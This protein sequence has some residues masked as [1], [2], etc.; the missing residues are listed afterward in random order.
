MFQLA[1]FV[2]S[3]MKQTAKAKE[4]NDSYRFDNCKNSATDELFHQG[5]PV[6]AAV[7]LGSQFCLEL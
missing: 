3:Q 4:I 5:N 7:D 2:Q 1:K 6:L